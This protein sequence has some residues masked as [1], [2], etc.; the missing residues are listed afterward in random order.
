[1]KFFLCNF[2]ILLSLTAVQAQKPVFKEGPLIQGYGK[3]FSLDNADLML[4]NTKQHRVV[5]DV[6]SHPGKEGSVNPLINTV[7]RFINMHLEHGLTASQME[8]ALVLHGKAV[9]AALDREENPDRE[10]IE[11]LRDHKVQIYVCGQSLSGKGHQKSELIEGIGMSVSAMTALV[12][13]QEADYA[14]INFN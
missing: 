13:F 11:I 3:I 5:F 1:M 14:L 12:H 8:I 7:A 6:F 2:L 9:T 4:D 10:L